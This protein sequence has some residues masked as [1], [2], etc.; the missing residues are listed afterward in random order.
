MG[1]GLLVVVVGVVVAGTVG[2]GVLAL[3]ESSEKRR[4][5]AWKAFAKRHGG[6]FIESRG[7]TGPFAPPSGAVEVRVG[8]VLVWLDL[9]VST[10]DNSQRD[11]RARA[12]FVLGSGPRFSV[13]PAGILSG[14]GRS[15]RFQDIP[16]GN[17]DFDAAFIVK[18]EDPSGIKAAWTGALQ[19]TLKRSMS[20]ASV[21]SDGKE[22]TVIARGVRVDGLD[23]FVD[24]AGALASVGASGLDA[25]AELPELPDTTLT[26]AGGT[27]SAPTPPT[28]TVTTAHG[29]ATA[30]VHSVTGGP[31]LCL[32]LPLSRELPDFRVVL[33]DGQ[34]EGMPAG[35]ITEYGARLLAELPG[36]LL[37]CE[38][39]QLQLRWLGIPD[40]PAFLAGVKLL[41]EVAGSAHRTGAFR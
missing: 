8:H 29:Q 21:R 13:T 19:A 3:N 27:W 24:V 5:D 35:L 1:A 9:C 12:R 7:S 14:V 6:R 40:A 11:T 20:V 16:L 41:S 25:L 32:T 10:S 15:I 39:Q 36:A 18:G 34:A 38:E 17:P 22:V 23:V 2:A 37:K 26:P 4:V 28:L 33:E 31:R 30:T